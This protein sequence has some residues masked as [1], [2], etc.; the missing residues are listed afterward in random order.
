MTYAV[1][2]MA[3]RFLPNVGPFRQLVLHARVGRQAGGYGG[4]AYAG[5]PGGVPAALQAAQE[6]ANADNEGR[7]NEGLNRIRTGGAD[8]LA[9]LNSGYQG[10]Q[11][12][13]AGLSNTNLTR[14]RSVSPK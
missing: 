2:A 12:Q 13:V 3:M 14:S 7:Y 1:V 4:A 8:Q 9:S 11:G 6:A 5:G 10:L